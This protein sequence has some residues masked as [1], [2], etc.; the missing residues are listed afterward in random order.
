MN[1][2]LSAL[3]SPSDRKELVTA[4]LVLLGLRDLKRPAKELLGGLLTMKGLEESTTYQE[5]VTEGEIKALRKAILRLG[6]IRFG[7]PPRAV[8]KAINALE[9]LGRLEQL[10]DR[11]VQVGG[12]EELLT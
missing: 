8:R 12:W 9:D 1:R 4:A 2:R 3:S 10:M 5:I 6:Q 11:V 7:A